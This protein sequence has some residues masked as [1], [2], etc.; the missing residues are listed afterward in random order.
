MTWR[1]G[2][3]WQKSA[4]E[5]CEDPTNLLNLLCLLAQCRF[6]SE[7]WNKWLQHFEWMCLIS[8]SQFWIRVVNKFASHTRLQTESQTLAKS[9]MLESGS[10]CANHESAHRELDNWNALFLGIT[11]LFQHLKTSKSNIYWTAG[12]TV[13]RFACERRT[14]W[15]ICT[16]VLFRKHWKYE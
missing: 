8:Y 6:R 10:S 9:D 15:S 1:I 12:V 13:Y 4:T 11:V 16:F 2:P 14:M 5:S 7:I 3:G